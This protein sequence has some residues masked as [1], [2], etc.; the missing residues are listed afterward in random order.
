MAQITGHKIIKEPVQITV[1]NSAIW[2]LVYRTCCK[3]LPA[4]ISNGV[5]YKFTALDTV[6]DREITDKE[7]ELIIALALV[8]KTFFDNCKE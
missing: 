8:E 4:N 2:D 6:F 1:D 5:V 7:R 3:A